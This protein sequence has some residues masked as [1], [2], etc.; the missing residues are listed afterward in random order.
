[1]PN[2]NSEREII[3]TVRALAS[4]HYEE[5][6]GWQVIVECMNDEDILVHA[7]DT[8]DMR[9]AL[10]NIRSFVELHSEQYDEIKGTEW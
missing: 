9:E 4:K 7:G 8:H 6:Y 2:Y 5:G 3:D 10:K 1:M